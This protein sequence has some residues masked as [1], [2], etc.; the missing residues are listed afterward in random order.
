MKKEISGGC[1]CGAVEFTVRNDF[2]RFYF[3][4]CEQ[5]RKMVGT[6]HASNLFTSPDNINWV[7]GKELVKRYDDPKRSFTQAFCPKCGSPLPYINQSGKNLV[8]PVGSLNEEPTKQVDAE[9]FCKEQPNWYKVGLKA[10]KFSGFP[11]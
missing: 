7:K 8:V 11:Q 3:C 4:H 5:C 2:S 9:I 6:A 10:P 1:Y